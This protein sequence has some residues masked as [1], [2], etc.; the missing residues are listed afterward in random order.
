MMKILK[1]TVLES[2]NYILD[3]RYKTIP[4]DNNQDTEEI[5]LLRDYVLNK[6]NLLDYKD[7]EI[8]FKTMEWVSS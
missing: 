7:P 1:K 4:T 6:I 8:I 5:K 2:S 3:N